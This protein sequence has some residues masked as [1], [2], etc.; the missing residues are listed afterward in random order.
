MDSWEFMHHFCNCLSTNVVFTTCPSHHS[1]F[2]EPGWAHF[3]FTVC[4]VNKIF[5]L[6]TRSHD[7]NTRTSR[8]IFIRKL[9]KS[10]RLSGR[11]LLLYDESHKNKYWELIWWFQF[12]SVAFEFQQHILCKM[13]MF[14]LIDF[15]VNFRQWSY[16]YDMH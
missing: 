1:E 7:T 8:P 16:F 5:N 12:H 6:K 2:I 15:K 3:Y 10:I 13:S 11:W 9:N 14:N 4:R